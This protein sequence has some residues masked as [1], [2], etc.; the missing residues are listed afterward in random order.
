MNFPQQQQHGDESLA[1]IDE[2]PKIDPD[3][4]ATSFEFQGKADIDIS[5]SGL[6]GDNAATS[7]DNI[8]EL[9]EPI[10]IVDAAFKRRSIPQ[11]LFV[12]SNNVP[13]KSSDAAS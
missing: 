10:N 7:D 5:E 8:S 1:I 12:P 9:S 4:H 6:C 2:G 3:H 13:I 11:A